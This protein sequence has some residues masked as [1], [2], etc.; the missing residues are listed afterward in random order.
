M[1]K[2]RK[3]K[4]H[5]LKSI[6]ELFALVCWRKSTLDIFRFNATC[7]WLFLCLVLS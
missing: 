2:E 4:V 3:T 5:R 1:Y 7:D 6:T